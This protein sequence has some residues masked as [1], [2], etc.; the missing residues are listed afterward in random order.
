MVISSASFASRNLNDIN[1]STAPTASPQTVS[2]GSISS[3]S[4]SLSWLPP[5]SGLQNGIIR[6]Y[7]IKLVESET[8]NIFNYNTTETSLT[9]S[10]L[11]PYYY[12]H[13]SVAA[14]TVG[15]GPF[16]DPV[17][18]QT[19]EDGMVGCLLHV[20]MHLLSLTTLSTLCSTKW[21][22]LISSCR[23]NGCNYSF[24]FL[25]TASS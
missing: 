5:A 2:G 21:S 25:A 22:T 17:I 3:T 8:G 11:H 7:E 6:R 9:I 16:T 19:P 13:C 14:Y 23:S 1:L 20:A 4:I 10:S 12:Y 24:H 18:I 15:L